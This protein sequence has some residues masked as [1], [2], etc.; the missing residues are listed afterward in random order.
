MRSGGYV[1]GANPALLQNVEKQKE[2]EK[3]AL[4]AL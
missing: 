2:E 3:E 4:L 1:L